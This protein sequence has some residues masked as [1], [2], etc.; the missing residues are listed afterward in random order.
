MIRTVGIRLFCKC[1]P[2]VLF[3]NASGLITSAYKSCRRPLSYCGLHALAV[4]VFGKK[5]RCGLR[6]FG[7]FLCSFAVF[8]PSLRPPPT[9]MVAETKILVAEPARLLIW[10]QR[11]FCQKNWGVA[12]R[13]LGN[14]ASPVDRT[15][16]LWRLQ[17]PVS[18]RSWKALTKFQTLWPH[19][20]FMLIFLI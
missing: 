2:S 18:R 16:V 7:V 4:S 17:T 12:R 10:T 3:Y 20:C 15:R 1:E 5:I 9:Q 6:F 19:S 11:S 13:D 8:G 14:W